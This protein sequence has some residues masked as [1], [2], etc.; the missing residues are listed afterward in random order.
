MENAQKALIMAGSALLFVIAI[1]VGIRAYQNVMDIVETIL[2]TSENN[3]RA[4]ESFVEASSDVE[5]Y[6]TRAEVI[7]AIMSMEGNDFTASEVM[8]NGLLF[9][10]SMFDTV[11]GRDTLEHNLSFIPTSNFIVSFNMADAHNPRIIYTP[12]I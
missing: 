12:T 10:K 7:M 8:V 4:S 11:A 1:S 3:D 9:Q 6:A 2:T 5:R